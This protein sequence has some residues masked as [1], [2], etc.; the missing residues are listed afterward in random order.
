MDL[1]NKSLYEHP[2]SKSGYSHNARNT[3]LSPAHPNSEPIKIKRRIFWNKIKIAVFSSIVLIYSA[4]IKVFS[5][6]KLLMTIQE[7]QQQ[8]KEEFSRLSKEQKDVLE[9]TIKSKLL[10]PELPHKLGLLKDPSPHLAIQILPIHYNLSSF[11]L[12]NERAGRYKN[13]S[14]HK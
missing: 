11:P 3:K 13:L 12:R 7:L 5:P 2:Q 1:K 14:A 9:K 10:N 6:T 4:P 8:S